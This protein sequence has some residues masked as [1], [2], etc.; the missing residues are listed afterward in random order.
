MIELHTQACDLLGCEEPVVLAGMGGVARSRLV[1][2]VCEAGGFGFLGMV[3]ERPDFI[4]EE[5]AKVRAATRR[6][7]GVNLVPAATSPALL[8]HQIKA[9]I[10]LG[11]EVVAL[12]WD[13][14]P[15]IIA[16]LRAAGILVVCQVGSVLEACAAQRAGAQLLI[17]QGLEAGGHVRGLTCLSSLL[18]DVVQ[19]VDVPVLAA[20]GIVDGAGLAAALLSGAQGVVV[21]TAFLATEES[22]AHDYHKARVLAAGPD[23]TI[24]TDAFHINWPAGAAVRVLPNSTV[25]DYE[26]APSGYP[27]QIVGYD[28][29]RPIYRFSTDSPLQSMTG[30]FEAMA[31]YAGQGAA[32]ISTLMSAADRLR[33]ITTEARKLLAAPTAVATIHHAAVEPSSPVCFMS[34]ADDLYLGYM[35][36]DELVEA[37]SE[38]LEAERA[39]ARVA[40]RLASILTRDDLRALAHSIRGDEARSCGV[41]LAAIA[42]LDS[43]PSRI[44]GSF[45]DKSSAMSDPIATFAPLNQ[46]LD[47]VAGKLRTLAPRIRDN[48]LH[49]RLNQILKAHEANMERVRSALLEPVRG[50]QGV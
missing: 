9:C 47:S 50:E 43:E 2:A 38:L 8:D 41:L 17:A 6:P 23:E 11:V 26:S 28:G 35:G 22:F 4:R 39:G 18:P 10:D 46:I 49:E 37:L 31:L 44:V 33:S 30:D 19:A 20:G 24:H 25:R 16:E 36:G 45:H 21:G 34:E 48:D 40:A 13:L 12:F 3:R 5:V 27:R 7:F 29:D 32:R 42:K 14:A 15:S 1:S